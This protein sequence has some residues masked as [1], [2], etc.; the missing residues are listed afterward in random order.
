MRLDGVV[1]A[2][3]ELVHYTINHAGPARGCRTTWRSPKSTRSSVIFRCFG[4]RRCSIAACIARVFF[5]TCRR[6]LRSFRD[7]E[8]MRRKCAGSE[9]SPTFVLH[10]HQCLRGRRRDRSRRFS[11]RRPDP[12]A[13]TGRRRV[14]PDE[15][16]ARHARDE[17]ARASVALQFED[18]RQ[19]REEFLDD[20][21]T[22]FPTINQRFAGRKNRYSYCMAMEPG[23]F[24]FKGIVKTDH[25]TGAQD[26]YDYPAK[27]N[28]SRVNRRWHRASARAQ[29]TTATSS[30]SSATSLKTLQNAMFSTPNR[31]Q[32]GPVARVRLPER[33]SSGTHACW[34]PL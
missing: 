21:Y 18:R 12:E 2:G 24:L 7:A 14:D 27:A 3:G 11:S 6:V 15:A 33:I 31:S 25:Q 8:G 16:I 17:N 1:D 13:S 34:A 4:I 30:R 10:S 5:E 32:R 28:F 19:T 20:R 29:K 23:W 26:R 9:A 22:E